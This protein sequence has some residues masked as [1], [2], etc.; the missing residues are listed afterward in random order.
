M[1]Y[2]AKLF[3]INNVNQHNGAPLYYACWKE[4]IRCVELLLKRGASIHTFQ[5]GREPLHEACRHDKLECAEM[6]LNFEQIEALRKL[7]VCVPSTHVS[8]LGTW[9]SRRDIQSL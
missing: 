6:L 1:A 7:G 3:P 4:S 8:V 9:R 5:S 2:I